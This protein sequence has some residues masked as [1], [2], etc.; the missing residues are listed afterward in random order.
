MLSFFQNKTLEGLSIVE[1]KKHRS[2]QRIIKSLFLR[3][4]CDCNGIARQ[5]HLS[6]PSAQASINELLSAGIIKEK[7]QGT[8]TGGRRPII[9]GLEPE[10]F[11][12]LCIDVDRFQVGL[13]ILDSR[14]NLKA[15]IETHEIC[16]QENTSYLDKI[17]EYAIHILDTSGINKE[18]L[19]GIGLSM[20]GAIDSV[21]GINYSYFYNPEETLA[22]A[23]ETKFKLPVFIEND[24]NVL[25]LAELWLGHARNKRNALVLL[26]SWGIGLGLI[27]DGKLYRGASGFA[28]E[29]SHIS[30]M[31]N[32]KLCWC[33]KQGCLETIA[34]A[35]A[36]SIL[37][38]EGIN[39]GS[40][41]SIFEA[42]DK[43]KEYIDP[44]IVIAAAN[45]GDQ[46][47]VNI[48]SEVGS[49]LGKG[50]ASLI[51]ILNPEIIILGGRMAEAKQYIT[52]PI[53]HALNSH[54]NPLLTSNISIT[55][56]HLGEEAIA[57]GLAIL[58]VDNLLSNNER[59]YN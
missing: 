40:A 41:S 25:A 1:K 23:L 57:L 12:L 16:F 14:L 21:N 28:G 3:G 56:T 37:V 10:S 5:V 29:F 15:G 19:I 35:T 45:N 50:I 20:P 13:T 11:Y 22:R 26:L 30:V 43:S 58:M 17:Y 59:M 54:C 2:K 4:D 6:V 39:N 31:D 18:L 24:T 51:Q 53:Q 48:L 49:K 34:S 7:G 38:K 36:L 33:N 52:T 27:L 32:G 46:F 8:S 44:S 9:Y 42:V 47:A 55:S